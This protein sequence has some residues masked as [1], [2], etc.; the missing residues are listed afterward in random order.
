M[1]IFGR[2]APNYLS[3]RS[4]ILK[5]LMIFRKQARVYVSIVTIAQKIINAKSAYLPTF[6]VGTTT[7]AGREKNVSSSDSQSVFNMN[8]RRSRKVGVSD[9][10][11]INGSDRDRKKAYTLNKKADCT[12]DQLN[13]DE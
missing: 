10:A 7:T 9:I 6:I 12:E 3:K 13:I 8:R 5:V 2:S 1:S 11:L 4:S